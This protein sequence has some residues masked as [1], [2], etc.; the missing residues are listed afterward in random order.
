MHKTMKQQQTL[1]PIEL[2]WGEPGGEHLTSETN[3]DTNITTIPWPEAQLVAVEQAEWSNAQPSK[4]SSTKA[5]QK[6]QLQQE[7]RTR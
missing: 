5:T 4:L 2:V 7:D 6:T 3:A 1:A